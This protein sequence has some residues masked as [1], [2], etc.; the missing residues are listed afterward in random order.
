MSGDASSGRR[1]VVALVQARMGSQR[2][3]GK[4]MGDLCGYPVIHWVLK[5]ATMARQLDMVVLTTSTHPCNDALVGVAGELGVESFRFTAEDDV[6]GR[7][8][9]AAR[10]AG[11]ATVIRVCADGP[12]I[13]PE[14]IDYAIE[15]FLAADVDYAF[16]NIPRLGNNYPDGL[17]TEV[18]S[19]QLLY[20]LDREALSPFNREA[21]FS[22]VWENTDRFSILPIDCPEAWDNRGDDIRLDIDWPG[23]LERMNM[24]CSELDVAANA[25]TILARWRTL[26]GDYDGDLYPERAK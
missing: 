22:Y 16:N 14:V 4:M 17:G 1:P 5:R 19:A 8:A 24:L 2:F 13:D 7:F 11:A 20:L 9:A 6:L 3:P 12:L 25:V 10:W 18:V 26:Y 21:A 15:A 23:D